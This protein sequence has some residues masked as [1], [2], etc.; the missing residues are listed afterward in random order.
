MDKVEKALRR[1]SPEQLLTPEVF[2]PLTAYVGEVLRNKTN[3]RWEMRRATDT[4]RTWEPWIVDPSG[5]AY[6]PF[7]IYKELLEN[8]RSSS[9]RAFV[10]FPTIREGPQDSPSPQLVMFQLMLPLDPEHGKVVTDV[11]FSAT[12]VSETKQPHPNGYP[13]WQKTQR[14]LFRDSKGRI[15]TEETMFTSLGQSTSSVVIRD[16]ATGTSFLLDPDQKI[17]VQLEKPLNR[18]VKN[19]PQQD[20]TSREHLDSASSNLKNEDLGTQIIAGITAQGSRRTITIPAEVIGNENPTAIVL[21]T[22]YSQ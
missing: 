1:L 22:W 11:P 20:T 5:R 15:R 19:T 2:A 16:P 6:A 3:G 21:E 7:G 17:V 18:G 13:I 10:A 14:N 9:L 4:E 12:A 8:G